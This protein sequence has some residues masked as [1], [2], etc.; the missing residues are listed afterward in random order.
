MID[1]SRY[2]EMGTTK[3]PEQ[4]SALVQTEIL[5]PTRESGLVLLR[6]NL[7]WRRTDK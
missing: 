4:K 7:R 6:W 3:A 5:C 1:R 2:V